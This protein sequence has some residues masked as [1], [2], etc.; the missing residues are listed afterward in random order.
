MSTDSQILIPL[1]VILADR[2]ALEHRNLSMASLLFIGMSCTQYP[3]NTDEGTN[4]PVANAIIQGYQVRNIM[5]QTGIASNNIIIITSSSSPP[6]F[7]RERDARVKRKLRG[8]EPVATEACGSGG[9]CCP[10][11][12]GPKLR[13]GTSPNQSVLFF[14]LDTPGG[15]CDSTLG[16]DIRDSDPEQA[17][18]PQEAASAS[19]PP[20]GG[21]QC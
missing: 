1:E 17:P 13:H 9:E 18:T 16:G 6:S 7:P 10:G 15:P 14:S 21:P 2:R 3:L 19:A 4:T 11:G 12:M 8:P 5:F 20:C